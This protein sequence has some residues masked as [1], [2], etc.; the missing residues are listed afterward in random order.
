MLKSIKIHKW[1]T[2]TK[3]AVKKSEHARTL[4]YWEK[5]TK[6]TL[7]TVHWFELV[8]GNMDCNLTYFGDFS[9][10]NVNIKFLIRLNLDELIRKNSLMLTF[11]N[12]QFRTNIVSL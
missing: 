5:N 7:Q 10:Y 4:T 9:I 6:N 11:Y 1:K 12:F 2:I 3:E 8:L